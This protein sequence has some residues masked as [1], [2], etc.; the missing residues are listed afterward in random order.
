MHLS[1]Y[2]KMPTS[3]ITLELLIYQES[4]I[5]KQAECGPWQARTK[6]GQAGLGLTKKKWL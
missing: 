2:K 6:I 4:M 1:I 3:S 5:K